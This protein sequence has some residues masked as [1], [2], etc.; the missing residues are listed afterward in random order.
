M[1]GEYLSDL[2][3]DDVEYPLENLAL[4]GDSLKRLMNAF[5]VQRCLNPA[6]CLGLA[7]SSLEES[8]RYSRDRKAFGGPIADFQ[9]MRWKLADM[10]VRIE[11]CRSLLYRAAGT[12][13]PFPDPT[14]PAAAKIFVN[15]RSE[16]RRVGEECVSRCET[17]W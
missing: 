17:W 5:N 12:A 3:F 11:A 7:E 15:T 8:V 14:P 4:R 2:R 16:K 6:I 10:F 13:D 9:G 1:G